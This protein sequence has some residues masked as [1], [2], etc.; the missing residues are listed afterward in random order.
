MG[1]DKET[2]RKIMI[3]DSELNF[4]TSCLIEEAN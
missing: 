3:G 2:I 1:I 4:Q